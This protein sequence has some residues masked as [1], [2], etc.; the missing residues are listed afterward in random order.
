MR[1]VDAPPANTRNPTGHRRA[2]C[3]RATT[4]NALSTTRPW[5]PCATCSTRGVLRRGGIVPSGTISSTTYFH[6]DQQQL[7]ALGSDY[8]LGT[9][10]ANQFSGGY[11]D[12][13]AQ[14]WTRDG[15]LLATSHQIVYFK[16]N[17]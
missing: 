9:A 7:D 12:Q 11:F 1:F 3:G 16:G 15:A 5:P 6:A 10:R 4:H 2:P 17:G 14:L 8:V 13:T